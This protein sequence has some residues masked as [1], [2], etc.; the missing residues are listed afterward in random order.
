MF[1]YVKFSLHFVINSL[2]KEQNATANK[3]VAAMAGYG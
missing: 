1:H 2:L 3:R